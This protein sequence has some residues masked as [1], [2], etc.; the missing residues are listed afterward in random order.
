MVA[1]KLQCSKA[2]GKLLKFFKYSLPI[3]LFTD[4]PYSGKFSPGKKFTKASASVLRKKIAR[5]NFVIRLSWI[6]RQSL[7]RR[8]QLQPPR[9]MMLLTSL[10][11]TMSS[12]LAKP[13]TK[14]RL[15]KSYIFAYNIVW[16]PGVQDILEKFSCGTEYLCMGYLIS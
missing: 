12:E 14:R 13:K 7:Q 5:F 8:T 11:M 16:S 4:I 2:R 9:K 3:I 6:S 10:R 15:M 1:T